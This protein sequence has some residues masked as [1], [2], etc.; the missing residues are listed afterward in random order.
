MTFD[1][2]YQQDTEDHYVISYELICLLKWLIEKDRDKLKKIVSKALS[3]GLKDKIKNK[4]ALQ[5]EEYALEDIQDTILEFFGTLESVILESLTEQTTRKAIENNLMPTVDKIDSTICDDA[6][7]R[8][9]IEKA[10]SKIEK[11]P[12]EDA[13]DRLY[14]ELLKQ[15]KPN[16]KNILN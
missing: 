4:N 3:C 15:W 7:V 11:N 12:Q 10:T 1:D 6:T 2:L 13:N 16:K 5:E 8:F 14:E 9:S